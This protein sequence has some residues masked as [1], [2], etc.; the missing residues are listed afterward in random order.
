ME[1]LRTNGLKQIILLLLISL[2]GIV[3]V[4]QLK[5]FIPGLLGAITLYILLRQ[6]Y[7]NLTI[8]RRWKKWMAA[9]VLIFLCVLLLALPIWIIVQ[10]LLPKFNYAFDHTDQIMAN[11]AHVI[12]WV[13]G[14]LPKLKINDEQIQQ[15][16]QRILLI[17]PTVINA[18]LNATASMVL[19]TLTAFFI[20][21]FML[22]SGRDMEKKLL[23]L[24]PLKEV[25][26][27]AL[28]VETKNMVVSNSVGIP[29][30]MICQ[31]IIA[32]IGY[33]LFG[34][35][36][37]VVWGI[38]TGVASILPLIGTMIV[39]IPICVVVFVKGDIGI[40]IGLS[41]YCAIVVSNIDNVLRFTILKR[42]GD[43]HPLITVFGVIL[44]LQ[45]FGLMGLIFGPLLVAYFILLIKIYRLEFS[46]KKEVDGVL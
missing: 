43:V 18:T 46:S 29:V 44:G 21:Y 28:W 11:A 23:S 1:F 33:W 31:C 19:N 10:L 40:A 22:M 38:L 2:I 6:Y 45:L 17:V 24:L 5:Y 37:P 7:F 35:E 4:W 25:N 14:N 15:G 16:L 9:M 12:D 20:L 32:V 36:Q 27:D 39:W 30:L 34:I 13:K 3:L 42:I 8:K 41:L 26:K